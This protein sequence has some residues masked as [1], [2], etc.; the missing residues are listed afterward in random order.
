LLIYHFKWLN[1]C[2][3]VSASAEV[4]TLNLVV[5]AIVSGL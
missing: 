4:I 3:A 1:A 5:D 2:T